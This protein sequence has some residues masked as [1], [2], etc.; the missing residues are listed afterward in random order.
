MKAILFALC[1]VFYF[2]A[3]AGGNDKAIKDTTIKNVTYKIYEGS[4]GGR[5]INVVSRS[6]NAYKKYFKKA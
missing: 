1:M 5:Y 4:K 3:F 2:A 6:G